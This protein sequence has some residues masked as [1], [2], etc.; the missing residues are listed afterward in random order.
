[1][2]TSE[3]DLLALVQRCERRRARRRHPHS[4][5][6]AERPGFRSHHGRRRSREGR[7]AFS[8][9]EHGAVGAEASAAAAVHAVWRD[10]SR[11]ALW[12]RAQGQACRGRLAPRHRR[13][14]DGARAMLARSTVTVCHTGTR[15]CGRK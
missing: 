6:A 3:R 2:T 5:A 4:D 9:D 12:H 8:S 7:R 10:S 15:I 13:A 1:V 11:R 14:A